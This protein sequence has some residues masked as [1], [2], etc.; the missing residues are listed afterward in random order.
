MSLFFAVGLQTALPVYGQESVI[1]KAT[2]I[3][4]FKEIVRLGSQNEIDA[5]N[6][7]DDMNLVYYVDFFQEFRSSAKTFLSLQEAITVAH[8]PENYKTTINLETRLM[9]IAS[10]IDGKAKVEKSP[11]GFIVKGDFRDYT[12]ETFVKVLRLAD[13]NGD[14]FI[15]VHEVYNLERIVYRQYA[16]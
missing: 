10:V 3:Q 7:I 13:N 11:Y 14:K 12:D 2:E 4:R 16:K 1:P 5:R 9:E 8:L 6:F 15:T